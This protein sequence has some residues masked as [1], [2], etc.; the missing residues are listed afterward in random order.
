M[1]GT[2]QAEYA[3]TSSLNQQNILEKT[4]TEEKARS[5][6]CRNIIQGRQ[7]CTSRSNE[8]EVSFKH[9]LESADTCTRFKIWWQ[10]IPQFR[11]SIAERAS[12]N[13]RSNVWN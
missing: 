13:F 5:K 10:R 3:A 11:S 9:A 2:S 8:E 12:A 7:V 4:Y 6:Q 1:S